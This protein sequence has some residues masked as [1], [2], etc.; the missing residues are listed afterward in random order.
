MGN[1]EFDQGYADLDDRVIGRR[2]RTPNWDY[3]GRQRLPEGHE[4][5]GAARSTRSST[6]DGVTVGVIGAVTQETPTLV[7]PAGIADLDFGDPV[8]AVNR[9]AAQLTDGD[10]SN[11]EAD[12]HRRR[13]PRGCRRRHARRRDPRRRRSPPDGAFA[14]IVTTTARR[15]RRHLHRPHAQAVRVGR[16]DP[17]CDRQDPPGAPD[18]QLRRE[19]RPGHADRRPATPGDVAAYT[20]AQRRP[21]H[22]RRRRPGRRYP[23][24]RDGQDDHRRG[25]RRRGRRSATSRSARSRPTSPPRSP[26]ARTSTACTPAARDDRARS[27]RSATSSPTRSSTSLSPADRGG[28]DI[29]IVNPGG[30]RAEL[31]YAPDGTSPTPR[32]T[33]CCRSSTTCGRRSLTGAQFKTVLEQ[34]WQLDADGNVPSRPY[35]QLGLS[36]QRAVHLRPHDAQGSAS[37]AS[38]WTA[39]R[40]TRRASYRIGTFNFL[41]P[42]AT[43]SVSSRTARTRATPVSSTATR[44][45]P[46]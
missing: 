11:G 9:V 27:R 28:A 22:G 1:H 40:S 23:R 18:R 7:S 16:A 24:G 10:A 13:V 20:A 19:H 8:E 29:G 14:D 3:L 36:R 37:R 15:R 42:V 44:G 35:L 5:P 38:R 34:Q 6:I 2:R 31:L 45:S 46:T 41:L 33:R 32:R 12:V 26:A 17:R 30:L 39:R 21:H 4:D 25:A 43:T